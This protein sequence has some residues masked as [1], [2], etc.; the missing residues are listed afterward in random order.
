MRFGLEAR[1][2]TFRAFTAK[3]VSLESPVNWPWNLQVTLAVISFPEQT[4]FTLQQGTGVF[5]NFF[6]SR[7]LDLGAETR[8]SEVACPTRSHRSE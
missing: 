1:A 4:Y 8:M 5:V 6:Y 3:E 2:T 7:L